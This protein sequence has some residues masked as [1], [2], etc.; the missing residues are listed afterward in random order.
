MHALEKFI[1]IL[2]RVLIWIGGCFLVAMVSLTCAN[3]FLR[4]VWVPVKGTY[5]LMGFFGAV[6]TAFA[7]GYTQSKKG[8]IAVDVLV[9]SFSGKTRRILN[10]VNSFICMCFFGFVSWQIA[11][12]AGV[13]RSSG[14]VTET[15][16]VIYHPF[17]YA[18]SIGCGFLA[19]TFL[20]EFLKSIISGK[21]GEQ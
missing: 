10:V 20:A 4:L 3:I 18:V 6:A 5:E 16:R 2:N 9:L 8:H 13:L 21:E 12:Y 15:L 7:L 11:K 19:L 17:T 14:E 1:L